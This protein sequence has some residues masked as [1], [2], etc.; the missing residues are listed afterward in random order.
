M[1][2]IRQKMKVNVVPPQI[3]I[4]SSRSALKLLVQECSGRY[5]TPNELG[6]YYTLGRYNRLDISELNAFIDFA[7]PL[8]YP[9]KILT[10][11]RLKLAQDVGLFPATGQQIDS[12]IKCQHL[13][14]EDLITYQRFMIP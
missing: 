5:P 3:L 10:G 9:K 8:K 13:D 14:G 4:V 2:T 12:W 7:S 11:T 1:R 6:L